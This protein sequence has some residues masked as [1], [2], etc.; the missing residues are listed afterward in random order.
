MEI[1]QSWLHRSIVWFPDQRFL[2]DSVQRIRCF[3]CSGFDSGSWVSLVDGKLT[4]NLK[5]GVPDPVGR[6]WFG[7]ELVDDDKRWSVPVPP[8]VA[9]ELLAA[10]DA[11]VSAGR[12][13]ALRYT[14]CTTLP[15]T[16]RFAA[17]LRHRLGAGLGFVVVRDFPVDT[18]K[19]GT[20]EMAYWL[21]GY[22]LGRPVSQSAKLDVIG[23]VEDRGADIGSPEQRGYESSAA[24]P[25][26]VDRTDVIGLLCV[27]SAAEGGLSRLVSSKAVHD[28]LLAERPDL[29][30]E[31]Y[32]PIPHDRRGEEQPAEAPWSGIPVFSRVGDSFATRY[33]RRFF[34][35]SQRHESA[36]RLT[37][38]QIEAM[39]ALDE[40]L[41]RP[42]VS[43]DME[44][45]RGD[46]Q[47]INNFHILH[48]RTA[49]VDGAERNRLLFRLWLAW[50]GSPALPPQ[51]TA[52]Y[53]AT[54]A[55]SYRGGVWPP[56]A[57][58]EE[59]GRPVAELT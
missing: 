31:L 19:P 21:L 23:R 29:L 6:G 5:T 11:E 52:L 2:P 59:I 7:R 40:I 26:H 45:G 54:A 34:T 51:F 18:G 1:D 13:P 38:C 9:D 37:G 44:L 41:E 28:L 36:P 16:R 8:D 10:A 3:V 39:D 17:D 15:A 46:L 32:E 4:S 50:Q 58:P 42:G 57:L 20:V 22:E 47:L 33:I 30:A 12:K 43:L 53:G 25:F 24:L 49:F 35:G 55:G 27:H 14:V 48:A 56:G